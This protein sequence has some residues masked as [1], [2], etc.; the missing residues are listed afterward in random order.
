MLFNMT[1]RHNKKTDE[2]LVTI[3]S[4]HEE[5]VPGRIIEKIDMLHN[6]V[7]DLEAEV[8]TKEEMIASEN[9]G[10]KALEERNRKLAAENAD[11]E[12][13]N[14]I[15]SNQLKE[16]RDHHEPAMHFY[17]IPLDSEEEIEKAEESTAFHKTGVFQGI[18]ISSIM[19]TVWHV[20]NAIF[21]L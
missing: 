11:L 18:A 14:K 1:N 16:I 15:L 9:Y 5:L 6:L 3:S 17:T 19:F 4:V 12:A 10:N 21:P 7:D 20:V 2:F 8:K 13:A